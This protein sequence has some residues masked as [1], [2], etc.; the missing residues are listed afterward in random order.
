MS[1]LKGLWPLLGSALVAG[2][3]AVRYFLG[4]PIKFR[5]DEKKS[6][7][8]S[9]P[10][11]VTYPDVFNHFLGYLQLSPTQK[12][13]Q[14]AISE[15]EWGRMASSI[16]E[17]QFLAWLI[18]TTHSKRIV[19]VGVFMGS[20]TLAIGQVLPDDGV[21]YALD[22][23]KQFTDFGAKAWHEAGVSRKI[24]LRLGLAVDSLKQMLDRDGDGLEGKIDFAFIDANK[25]DYDAY[26]E[27]CLRLLRKGGI[28]AIDNVYWH[29][30]ILKPQ[31]DADALAISAINDKIAQDNR[32]TAIT[33][34]V[35][36]GLTL[37]TKL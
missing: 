18:K 17:S 37:C 31:K 35:A 23:S 20:T 19:E 34:P 28:V 33:I 3:L 15:H 5:N 1:S 12:K 4:K 26:Y 8:K 11:V 30:A 32:V 27:L 22:V 14:T 16:D 6:S 2:G 25:S 21:V 13:L 7:S 9:L 10:T 36:D 24:D 29:G